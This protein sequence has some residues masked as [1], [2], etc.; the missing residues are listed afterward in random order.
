MRPGL[1]EGE[2]SRS[3]DAAAFPS[4]PQ[5]AAPEPSCRAC[6]RVYLLLGG[7]W[8]LGNRDGAFAAGTEATGRGRGSRLHTQLMESFLET[9]THP[10]WYGLAKGT[11]PQD[12]AEKRRAEGDAKEKWPGT[13]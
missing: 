4:G 2:V 5:T 1:D 12:L 10:Q 3:R 7:L 9:D 11:R 6:D 8:A 13:S